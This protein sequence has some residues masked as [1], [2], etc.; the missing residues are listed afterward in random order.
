MALAAALPA[1]IPARTMANMNA[2]ISVVVVLSD[3]WQAFT[4]SF[5][6]YTVVYPVSSGVNNLQSGAGVRV[7]GI[8][9]GSVL[10]VRPDLEGQGPFKEIEVE[11]E[12]DERIRLYEGAIILVTSPL[13]GSD[14]WLDIIGVGDPSLGTPP[15]LKG[16]ESIGM[17]SALL[18]N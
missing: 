10:D 14:A 18:G 16:T 1:A 4:K 2:N 8:T 15:I 5:E 9:L 6:V 17:L 7:G 11:F 13:I 12:I 3:V